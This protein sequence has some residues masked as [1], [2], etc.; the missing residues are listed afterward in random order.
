MRLA[1]GL[2]LIGSM[3]AAC[4]GTRLPKGTPPPEYEPPIVS[5]WSAQNADAGSDAGTP[6]TGEAPSTPAADPDL[7]LDAG[8]R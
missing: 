1:L 3:F 8:P 2:G 4:S 5:P 7:S 6:R